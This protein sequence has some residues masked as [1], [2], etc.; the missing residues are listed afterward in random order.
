MVTRGAKNFI[1]L[2]RSGAVNESS[3]LFLSEMRA[4]RIDIQTPACDISDEKSLVSA[5]NEC[6]RLMP[7]IR[8]C[9]QAAMVLKVGH[10]HSVTV[11]LNPHPI[12]ALIETD[13]MAYSRI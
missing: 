3:L 13:R 12:R 5:L 9:I 6:A 10:Y 4:K 8:G 1:L 2:S 7:P 11:F